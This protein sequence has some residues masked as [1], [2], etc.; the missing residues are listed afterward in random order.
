MRHRLRVVRAHVLAWIGLARLARAIARGRVDQV[1]IGESNA[2]FFGGDR[3]PALG[4]GSTIE[5]QWVWHL[6][7]RLMYSIARDDFKP[8]M[9]RAARLL[10]RLSRARDVV[11]VFSLGEIDIRCHLAPRVMAGADLDFVGAYVERIRA[12]LADLG[13]PYGVIM[14]PVPPATQQFVHDSFPVRGTNEERLATHGILRKRLI[15]E[16]SASSAT[17]QLFV[18]DST[19]ALSDDQGW[20]RAELHTDGVH[21][22]DAGR[23]V[24]QADLRRVLATAR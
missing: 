16:V 23:A 11:W 18:L 21:P 4:V 14:V 20:F 7:P 3:F 10:G 17:P 15:D 9:H 12:L 2:A 1:W 22:N 13:A 5:R 19:D 6:G 8:S 24:A